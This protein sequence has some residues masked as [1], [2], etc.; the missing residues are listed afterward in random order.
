MPTTNYPGA[1]ECR[2]DLIRRGRDLHSGCVTTAGWDGLKKRLSRAGAKWI[3]LP[4]LGTRRRLLGYVVFA[5]VL[6]GIEGEE[7]HPPDQALVALCSRG[8]AAL[9]GAGDAC[10]AWTSSEPTGLEPREESASV[11]YE[12]P[13]SPL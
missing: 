10:P 2:L 12:Y 7:R 13:C 5:D 6:L 1:A 8:F 9:A 11:V 4:V 3:C